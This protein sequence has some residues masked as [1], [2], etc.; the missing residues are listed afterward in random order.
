MKKSAP[1]PELLSFKTEDGLDLPGLLY[2]PDRKTKRALLYLHGNGDSSILYKVAHNNIF[3]EILGQKGV[4]YFPFN[5]RGGQFIRRF[6]IRKKGKTRYTLFGSAYERIK[7]CVLDIDAALS[8]LRSRGFTEFYLMG[9]STGANKICVYNYH[10]PRNKIKKYVLSAGG[11]DTGHYYDSVGPAAFV[12]LVK[13][14]GAYARSRKKYELVTNLFYPVIS[15][16]SLYDTINPNGDYNIF[17]YNEYF[18]DLQISR[19]KLFREFA[20]IKKPTLVVYGESDEYLP[21][22]VEDVMKALADHTVNEQTNFKIIKGANHSFG[23]Q[24]RELA[25][26]IARWLTA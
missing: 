3:A 9:H 13:K 17:P 1:F 22:P 8:F 14:A 11:D 5:N 15:W 2:V 10:K 20:E 18:N 6:S 24:E 21:R 23:G 26:T 16:Q 4:A 12:K 7:D 19:K 25:R